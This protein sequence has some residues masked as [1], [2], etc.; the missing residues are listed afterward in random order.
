[1]MS[2]FTRKPHLI[3][4]SL[5]G[6]LMLAAAQPVG[7][8]SK[9]SAMVAASDQWLLAQADSQKRVDKLADEKQGMADD[10][11]NTLR[12]SDSLKLYLQQLKAQLGS[13]QE[14][15]DSIR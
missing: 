6:L 1:M 2:T 9:L 12:E 5:L 10:Y 3:A 8:D 4:S 14:E 7:A 15:M 11:R 13:Q